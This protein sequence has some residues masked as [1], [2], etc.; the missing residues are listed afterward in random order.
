MNEIDELLSKVLERAYYVT[1][2]SRTSYTD[3]HTCIQ[4]DKN[5]NYFSNSKH[6][7]ALP[8]IP[9]SPFPITS[10]KF[11]NSLSSCIPKLL[12]VNPP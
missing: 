5:S 6:A 7:C 3:V 10:L 11:E 8:V 1:Q 4:W 12:R 9:H 2:H